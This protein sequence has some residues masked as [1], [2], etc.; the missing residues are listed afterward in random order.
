[1]IRSGGLQSWHIYVYHILFEVLLGY[2]SNKSLMFSYVLT[3]L[4]CLKLL[5][6]IARS[7]ITVDTVFDL[8]YYVASTFPD[9]EVNNDS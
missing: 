8:K 9:C 5:L 7:I 6:Q 4:I 2:T 3:E 1:M